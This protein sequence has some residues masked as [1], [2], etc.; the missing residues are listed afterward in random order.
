MEFL[1]THLDL[2]M[3][4]AAILLLLRGFPVAFTLAGTASCSP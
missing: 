2:V 4:A 1:V 3:F